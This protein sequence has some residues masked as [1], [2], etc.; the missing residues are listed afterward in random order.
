MPGSYPA[1][2]NASCTALM[3]FTRR[4]MFDTG[5]TYFANGT[6]QR[7]KK[8][9]PLASFEFNNNS[10]T[11]A[12]IALLLTHHLNQGGQGSSDWSLTIG[13]TTWS[14][15]ALTNDSF[16][17]TNTQGLIYNTKLAATQTQ[18]KGA[19]IPSVSAVWPTFS[20]GAKL[21]YPFSATFRNLT[22]VSKSTT[23]AQWSFKWLGAGVTNQPT[24]ALRAFNAPM[25]LSFA[26][27]TTLE[28]FFTWAQGRLNTFSFTDPYNGTTYTK[29]RFDTDVLELNYQ[30]TNRVSVTLPLVEIA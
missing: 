7:W 13:S 2:R 30:D 11:A 19:T 17:F 6:E 29:V 22:T 1:L 28:T 5:V 24:R 9:A 16:S 18:N 20:S 8:R 14:N 26:D 15:L 23:G 10:L 3:P 25:V 27:A 21:Q 12:D 4:V